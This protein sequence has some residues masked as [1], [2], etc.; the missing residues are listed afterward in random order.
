MGPVGQRPPTV[1]RTT[2][3]EGAD[4][5][6]ADAPP[7]SALA[8]GAAGASHRPTVGLVRDDADSTASPAR[9]RFS[10]VI[11][12]FNESL[13]IAEY[14]RW[15]AAQDFHE[16]VEIIVVDNNSTDGP[17]AIARALGATVVTERRPGVCWA[18]QRG[19]RLLAVRSSCLPTPIPPSARAGS[20]ASTGPSRSAR[21]VWRLP[22][23]PARRWSTVGRGLCPV[24]VRAG[25][26]AYRLTARCSTSPARISR[27]AR[28]RGAVMTPGLPR[29]G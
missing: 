17:V 14:L 28:A 21:R 9:A 15:L 10:V 27:S 4:A 22:T 7:R 1:C 11:P 29:A 3:E 23:V 19:P 12:A 13:L 5:G 24:A 25:L 8:I 16:A 18:R 2:T 26:C 20:R 6:A